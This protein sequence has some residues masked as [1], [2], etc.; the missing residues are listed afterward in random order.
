METQD[1][2]YD[3][4]V[5]ATE[6]HDTDILW[7]TDNETL[8][9]AIRAIMERKD[10]EIARLK[11]QTWQPVSRSDIKTGFFISEAG[12]CLVTWPDDIRLCHQV[13]P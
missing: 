9:E 3:I 5:R 2:L 11:A 1:E 10:A 4:I 7:H 12:Q 6:L 8:Y 13:Q